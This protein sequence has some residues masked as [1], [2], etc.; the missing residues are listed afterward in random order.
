MP[1][2][3]RYIYIYI[4]IYYQRCCELFETP[5][6]Q[7][8]L[9]GHLL[10]PPFDLRRVQMQSISWLPS[11]V[12]LLQLRVTGTRQGSELIIIRRAWRAHWNVTLRDFLPE[13][14]TSYITTVQIM[15]RGSAHVARTVAQPG[16]FKLDG[17]APAAQSRCT[18]HQLTLQHMPASRAVFAAPSDAF[19]T[20]LTSSISFSVCLGS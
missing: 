13:G 8:A 15:Y 17:E 19:Q 7:V 14:D 10:E 9:F 1:R 3:P 2:A 12:G 20:C 4:F 6:I 11:C 18:Q 16:R 5:V